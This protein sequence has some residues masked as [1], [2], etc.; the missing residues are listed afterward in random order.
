M[1]R[2]LWLLLA[3]NCL[4]V[5]CACGL[6]R[7]AVLDS[8]T[9]SAAP[10]VSVPFDLIDNRIVIDVKL[11]GKGPFRFIFDT[12]AVSVVSMELAR[13]EGLRVEGLSRGSGGVG[14]STVERG[15]TNISDTAV[16]SVHLKDEDYG[17]LSFA[18]NKY[19]FG[20][21]RIDGIIG[22]PLFKRFVVT[23]D[24]ERRLL[25]FTEPGQFTYKGPGT[26]VP[27]DFDRHLPLVKG[28]LDD[29]PGVFVIDTG[30]RSALLL[31]GPFVEQHR[32]REK[33][34]ASIEGITGWG[35]GGPVRSQIVRT[36]KLKLGAVEVT[37]LVARLSLQRSSSLTSSDHAALV[38]PDVLKQ[39]TTIFDYS[40]R[41]IIF[42]KN[43]EY[44]KPDSYDRAGMW[45][46]LEGDHF[47]VID[48]MAGGPAAEAGLKVGDHILTIDG[49]SVTTLDLPS[50]RLRFK[51][52]PVKERIRLTIE[53]GGQRREVV[54]TLRDLV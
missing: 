16:G 12:G 38:G 31:Y 47:E 39:F 4:A 28:E 45:F 18:D 2:L 44:G 46:G 1:R 33:Y 14:E 50:A 35:I 30:A 19:V 54:L 17:V 5:P 20:A 11:D 26:V 32:L 49:Q 7:T 6:G 8:T 15:Q 36:L 13:A 51:N 43:A 37:N 9:A 10:A 23:V 25:T 52:D 42:E 24:Y 41:Q 27:I 53:H 3:V 48:V 40:R 34:R 29:I 22:Y 21:N